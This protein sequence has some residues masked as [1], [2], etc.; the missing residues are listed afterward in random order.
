[1]RAP[2]CCRTA[3]TSRRQ[4]LQL[5]TE[6]EQHAFDDVAQQPGRPGDVRVRRGAI[7]L[8]P[9]RE[10]LHVD[11]CADA[12]VLLMKTYSEPEHVNVGSGE[13]LT[14]LEL[15]RLVCQVVGYRGEIVTDPSR[16]DGAPRKLMNA[17]KLRGMGWAPRIS[18]A[19]GIA[20]AYAWRLAS[21]AA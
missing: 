12:L 17:D 19:E 18:L 4:A 8:E 15:A 11:D 6:P 9:R 5:E 2:R 21:L 1:M 16:P 20:D 10:F 13:D 3:P 7:A 14:I